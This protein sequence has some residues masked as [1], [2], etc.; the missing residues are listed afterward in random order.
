MLLVALVAFG[1]PRFARAETIIVFVDGSRME[2]QSYEVKEGVV[3]FKTKEGKLRSVPRSYVN[4]DATEQANRGGEAASSSPPPA[5]ASRPAPA[6]STAPASKAPTRTPK[7]PATAPKAQAP[8]PKATAPAPK[9]QAPAPEPP[10][11]MPTESVEP[12]PPVKA[13]VPVPV[14]EPTPAPST[15]ANASANASSSSNVNLPATPPPVWSNDELRVSLAVPSAA[16]KIEGMP[17]SFD[18]AVALSN[19]AGGAKATL[20]LIRQKIRSEK[21]FASA[22]RQVEASV[23]QSPGYR[24]IEKG[25]LSL[26]PYTAREFRFVRNAGSLPVFNRLVVYYSRDLAYVLSLTCPESRREENE[27][28]F[29]ALVRGL[30]I[31]KS[32]K[33]LSF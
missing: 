27:S 19:E 12:E 6:P 11:E 32:R 7:A 8:A 24:E 29:E 5:A 9:A 1:A 30:V 33:E 13:P 18:V 15:N 14:P 26:D 31:K 16:W 20:A 23:S 2:I 10:E 25:E 22:V 28:D 3:L 17:P 4:L 21:D